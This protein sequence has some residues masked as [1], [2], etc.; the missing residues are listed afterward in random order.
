[1]EISDELSGAESTEDL[2]ER[3]VQRFFKRRS[4]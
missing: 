3:E 4:A 1:M 2:F